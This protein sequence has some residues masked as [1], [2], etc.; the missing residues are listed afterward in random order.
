MSAIALYD[1]PSATFD[2]KVATSI[3]LLQQVAGQ[4]SALTQASSLGAEDMVVTHLIHLAGI[5]SGVFVLDTGK[6]HPQTLTLTTKIGRAS[7]RERV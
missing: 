5:E 7:C 3:A 6:L 2:A 1:R 4:H